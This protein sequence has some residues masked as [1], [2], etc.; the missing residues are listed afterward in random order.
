[1]N[2]SDTN[3]DGWPV[4][5]MRSWLNSTLLVALP[6]EL[7][8]VIAETTVVSG[9]DSGVFITTDK[10]YLLSPKEV[11]NGNAANDSALSSTRQLDYYEE[12]GVTESSYAKAIKNNGNNAEIWWLRSAGSGSTNRFYRVNRNGDSMYYYA[13]YTYGVSPA[14]RIE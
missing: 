8:N 12:N 7:Q 4:T 6:L 2:S 9:G 14:F 11:W 13:S 3:K 1:M 10:L 5:S